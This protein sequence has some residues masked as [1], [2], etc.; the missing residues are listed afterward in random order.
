MYVY[1]RPKLTL[2]V[3]FS[4]FF[5]HLQNRGKLLIT[6]E[7]ARGC[8]CPVFNVTANSNVKFHI[9]GKEICL[10]IFLNELNDKNIIFFT[11][12]SLKYS[13]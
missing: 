1:V 9:L 7:L 10:N 6:K 4:V 3:Y 12:I 8:C 11:N 13:S 2:L 5:V